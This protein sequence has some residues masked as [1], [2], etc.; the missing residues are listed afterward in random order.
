MSLYHI[1]SLLY[2][3]ERVCLCVRVLESINGIK[4][5]NTA[6]GTW[7]SCAMSSLFSLLRR[8]GC[9]LSKSNG[10]CK[11][12]ESRSRATSIKSAFT[13]D[14]KLEVLPSSSVCI[15]FFLFFAASLV[16]SFN[17]SLALGSFRYLDED[18]PTWHVN[19]HAMPHLS[20]LL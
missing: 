20:P 15:S 8:G 7:A 2:L 5:V 14:S 11:I 10:L 12:R 6:S 17:A 18:S 4:P 9:S 1:I 3:T 16:A 19:V 13:S